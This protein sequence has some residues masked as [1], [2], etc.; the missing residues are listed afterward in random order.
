MSRLSSPNRMHVVVTS[1]G[2]DGDF[3]PLLAIAA[4][5]VRRGVTVTFVANP[6]YQRRV[7]QTGSRF[8]GAGAYLDLFA[9]LEA[10]PRYLRT[11]T[12]GVAIWKELVAPSIRDTYPVVRDVVREVGATAV[13]SHVLSYG[14]IWAATAAGV[15]NVVVTTTASAWLSRHQP[16]VFANWRAPRVVQGALSVALRGIGEALLRQVLRRLAIAIGASIPAGA[17]PD[18]DLNLGT[19]PEWFRPPAADDPPR[20][21]MCGFVYDVVD[22]PQ[23]LPADVDAF[24]AG[25][26]PPVVAGFGSA[27]S[28]HAAE[29]YRAVADACE[30]LGRRCVLIGRSAAAV[31]PN[32]NRLVLAYAPYARLFPAASA[33]VH[34][35]GFG[36]C[37]EVLRA[38]TPSLIAPFVFDQFDTAARIQDAG[39]GC[40]VRG[41]TDGAAD[42]AAALDRVF[43]SD[44]I[45]AAARAAAATIASAPPGADRAAE[46]IETV[47]RA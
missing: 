6:F 34:H 1:F 26:D 44:A 30:R 17:M 20:A 38:G 23:P 19:W 8:V 18:P 39:L 22:A 5:L 24:L 14:G 16:M 45:A 3:N 10:N 35:G 40:W 33:V 21:R 9:M 4:A 2:S 7:E 28:L 11:G 13:V 43:R 37:A 27:A 25:G 29:R 41:R 32:R 36:T 12:G 31:A 47:A 42:M 46:L 15:R